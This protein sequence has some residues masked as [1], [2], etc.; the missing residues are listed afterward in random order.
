MPKNAN[1]E[2]T[3]QVSSTEFISFGFLA[4]I[5]KNKENRVLFAFFCVV[6]I[7]LLIY[8]FS[9]FAGRLPQNCREIS[10][11][12]FKMIVKICPTTPGVVPPPTRPG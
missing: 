1:S 5:L 9:A 11:L 7:R 6:C 2:N 8:S 3:I 12:I 10:T 4:P